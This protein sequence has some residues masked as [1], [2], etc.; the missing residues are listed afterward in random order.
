[1]VRSIIV[2]YLETQCIVRLKAALYASMNEMN[3]EEETDV[4]YLIGESYIR[5]REYEKASFWLRKS[6]NMIPTPRAYKS[7]VSDTV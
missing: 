5:Y 3:K 7:L 1:M 4:I 6:I 2:F